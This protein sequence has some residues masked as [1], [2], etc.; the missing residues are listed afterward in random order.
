MPLRIIL[1]FSVFLVLNS[2]CSDSKEMEDAFFFVPNQLEKEDL[3]R[4]YKLQ[5]I[6]RTENDKF[7]EY[8]IMIHNMN[9]FVS[10]EYPGDPDDDGRY[11]PFRFICKYSY[12][13]KKYECKKERYIYSYDSKVIG[14]RVSE[15]MTFEYHLKTKYK[16][17]NFGKL[18][19][20]DFTGKLSTKRGLANYNPS[21]VGSDYLK[22]FNKK[23]CK[24]ITPTKVIGV[25][26]VIKC[27]EWERDEQINLYVALAS[28]QNKVVYHSKENKKFRPGSFKSTF[29][30]VDQGNSS[31][32]IKEA[33]NSA[34]LQ[35]EKRNND[36]NCSKDCK[37]SKFFFDDGKIEAVL[38]HKEKG[39]ENSIVRQVYWYKKEQ[40]RIISIL[41]G[42]STAKGVVADVGCSDNNLKG[43]I[44][45]GKE[46]ELKGNLTKAQHYFMAGCGGGL[47]EGCRHTGL[48][49]QK[50]Q[51]PIDALS[52]FKV[53]C[54]KKD[55]VSCDK[56]GTF[57]FNLKRIQSSISFKKKACDLGLKSSCLLAY[58]WWLYHFS[59]KKCILGREYNGF[60]PA[61]LL[62]KY[63]K[64]RVIETGDSFSYLLLDCTETTLAT[65]LL[66]GKSKS[67]CI[68]AANKM[69]GNKK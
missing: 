46:E 40:E 12:P 15:V 20:L 45:R 56:V 57:E 1:T 37:A 66:F 58:D 43:C 35:L 4:F 53:G 25:A 49:L 54:E 9:N 64:C 61:R 38:L 7:K 26:T 41:S 63:K 13:K 31:P 23:N 51:S 29:W 59:S 39:D 69:L 65:Q 55:A 33:V 21:A 48:V 60:Y 30:R 24:D 50:K 14:E 47:A 42:E 19:E 44:D 27:W 6:G 16:N 18:E 28:H 17:T 5:T 2:S 52:F 10:G 68:S 36:E 11:H 62:D 8:D 22:I 3:D 67:T 32:S 34:M